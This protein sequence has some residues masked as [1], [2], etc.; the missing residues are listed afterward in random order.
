MPNWVNNKVRAKNA[1]DTKKLIAMLVRKNDDGKLI[2]NFNGI[3]PMPQELMDTDAGYTGEENDRKRTA[4]KIKYGYRD[5]YDFAVN[6]WGTK[7]DYNGVIIKGNTI[8]FE[9]AWNI[10]SGIYEEISKTIPIIVAYADE[11]IGC[12]CGLVEFLNGGCEGV[13]YD[14]DETQL[15]NA[16]WGYE[17]DPK[18]EYSK[19]EY[20]NQDTVKCL[21]KIFG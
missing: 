8:E 3:I 12:N 17:Y 13:G 19:Q 5:W 2:T 10:P 11:D 20:Y 14:G 6:K 1:E 21:K 16:V 15:A 7:W 18:D 9:T 4:N